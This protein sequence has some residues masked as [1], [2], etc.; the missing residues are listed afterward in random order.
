MGTSLVLVRLQGYQLSCQIHAR[1]ARIAG[2]D[3]TMG[4]M[5]H[6]NCPGE[7][8]FHCEY[9]IRTYKGEPYT[10]INFFFASFLH[11]RQPSQV[12]I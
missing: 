8:L 1:I 6:F 12:A 9:T 4:G 2:L 11:S 7:L 3:E 10:G 5:G